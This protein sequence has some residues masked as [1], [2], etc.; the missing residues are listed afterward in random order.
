MRFFTI[1]KNE[2]KKLGAFGEST[3]NRTQVQLCYNRFKE[4]RQNVNDDARPGRPNTL[5]TD[6][7]IEAVKKII[8]DNRRIPIREIADDLVISFSSCQ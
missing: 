5:T 7:N 3:V 8:L 4:G 6:E 1:R 2:S